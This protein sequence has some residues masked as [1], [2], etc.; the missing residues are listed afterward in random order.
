VSVSVYDVREYLNDTPRP[1]PA[2][3]GV[4]DDMGLG[5]G[6]NTSFFVTYPNVVPSSLRIS[7]G[8]VAQVGSVVRMVWT[9]QAPTTYT[10]Q[11]QQITF[12]S[13]P[14]VNTA[15]GAQYLA[16]AFSDTALQKILTN[17]AGKYDTDQT[18]MKGCL[19]DYLD[20]LLTDIDRLKLVRYSDYASDA[21]HVVQAI[22]AQKKDLR[23]D[24][25]GG[26]RPGRQI[27]TIAVQLN[28]YRGF[29][30]RR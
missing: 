19:Y 28:T 12:A 17:N 22:S 3:A 10:Q 9:V 25:E 18:I 6:A 23:E 1:W 11:G 13:A 5:D 21:R 29:G 16:T 24:L 27:P 7:F 4:Y 2:I 14:A 15:I 20:V 8:T 30:I 26:P